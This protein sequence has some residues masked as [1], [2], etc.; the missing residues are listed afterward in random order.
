MHPSPPAS[1][2]SDRP[3]LARTKALSAQHACDVAVPNGPGI[4]NVLCYTRL[5][6]EM[7]LSLGRPLRILTAPLDPRTGGR[8]R[9]HPYPLWEHNPYVGELVDLEGIDPD[10]LRLMNAE[11]DDL[12]QFSHVIENICACY[13]LRPRSL[14]G[15]LFLAHAEMA[16]ALATLRHLPRPIVALHP[17]GKTA[18]PQHS[19]WH[20]REWRSLISATPQ[21]SYLQLGIEEKHLGAYHPAADLRTAIA[22]IWASDAFIGFDSSLAH[23]AT[24]LQK[25]TAVLWDAA[26]KEPIEM[27]KQ[28]GFAASLLMRWAYP[29]NRNL[30]LLGERGGEIQHL[31]AEFL[32]DITRLFKRQV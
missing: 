25:P 7:A 18:S 5:V 15:S 9:D 14:R 24:A 13:G 8:S 26:L 2:F 16:T 17:F 10:A 30:V 29:Q 31:C 1:R 32:A 12:C 4:G 20:A 27:R 22:L 21:F 28:A 6:E 3:P 11:K 23:V 19:P